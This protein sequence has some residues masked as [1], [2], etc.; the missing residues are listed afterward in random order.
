MKKTKLIA[1]AF[2]L[3]ILGCKSET[4]TVKENWIEKPPSQSPDF[5]L[6]NETSFKDT[7]YKVMIY[8]L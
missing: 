8:I 4:S 1:R 7:I 5:A 6:T 3:L 2:L